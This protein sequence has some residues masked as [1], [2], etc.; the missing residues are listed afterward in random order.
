MTEL[1]C[2]DIISG[3]F[4]Q[5]QHAANCRIHE[6]LVS[7]DSFKTFKTDLLILFS[8]G[9]SGLGAL[10]VSGRLVHTQQENLS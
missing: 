9:K 5:W 1:N 4:E 2:D 8:N 3:V 10:E 7:S 6:E